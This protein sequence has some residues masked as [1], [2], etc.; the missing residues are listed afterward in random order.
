MKMGLD[1]CSLALKKQI[2]KIIL[3]AGDSD[4]IPAAKF[5]RREGIDPLG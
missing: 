1:I 2:S 5:S 3:F 4:V